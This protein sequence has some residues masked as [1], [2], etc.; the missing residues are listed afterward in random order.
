MIFVLQKNMDIRYVHI[1]EISMDTSYT[2]TFPVDDYVTVLT[3]EIV[4]TANIRDIS[5]IDPNSE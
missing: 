3:V 4:G 5:F 2:Q 1:A